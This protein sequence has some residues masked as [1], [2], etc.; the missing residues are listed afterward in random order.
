MHDYH[1]YYNN[2]LMCVYEYNKR[3]KIVSIWEEIFI[4]CFK[5]ESFEIVNETKNKNTSEKLLLFLFAANFVYIRWKLCALLH[6]V[7]IHHYKILHACPC[8][9]II[10]LCIRVEHWR[11]APNVANLYALKWP[12]HKNLNIFNALYMKFTLSGPLCL[13]HNLRTIH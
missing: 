5:N 7:R 8:F 13:C 1:Y 12:W 2:V 6:I 11:S 9:C 4:C 10:Y 3:L